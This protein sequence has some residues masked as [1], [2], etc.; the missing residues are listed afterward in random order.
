L[1]TEPGV[2]TG[3][4]GCWLCILVPPFDPGFGT[5][6]P[7]EVCA[8]NDDTIVIITAISTVLYFNFF[9]IVILYLSI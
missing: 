6:L 5:E 9:M 2:P 4:L 8:I 3:P 7:G 1:G